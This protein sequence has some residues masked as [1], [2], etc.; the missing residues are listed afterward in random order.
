[1]GAWLLAGMDF[2][3]TNY[4]MESVFVAITTALLVFPIVRYVYVG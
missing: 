3:A 2:V 4:R 1:M